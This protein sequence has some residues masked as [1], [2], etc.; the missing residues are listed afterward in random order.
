V[1]CLD[2]NEGKLVKVFFSPFLHFSNKSL[3]GFVWKMFSFATAETI[4]VNNS[5]D[6]EI[7]QW[8]STHQRNYAEHFPYTILDENFLRRLLNF[9]FTKSELMRSYNNSSFKHSND[10][11]TV[12]YECSASQD[13]QSAWFSI[14][15]QA[16][17]HFMYIT[18]LVIAIF[19]NG[20]VCFIVCTSSRMQTV[21]N[22]FIA[23]LALSDMLMAFFCIPFSFISLFVLQ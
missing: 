23:N 12:N 10:N 4:E 20:I 22:F 5:N 6:I 11:D 19:G 2:K 18:I 14:E 21:T 16:T 8:N 9:T 7:P 1:W 17:L 13:T 15:F 3:L